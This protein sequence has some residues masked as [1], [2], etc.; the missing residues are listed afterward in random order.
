MSQRRWDDFV[1]GLTVLLTAVIVV[2]VTMWVSG[3]DTG[4]ERPRVEARFRDVGNLQI[5][6]ELLVRG[7]RAGQVE[8]MELVSGGWVQVGFTVDRSALLPPD[9]VVLLGASSLLGEWQATVLDRSELPDNPDVQEAI[10]E[11]SGERDVLPGATLPDLE[12]LTAAAGRIAGDIATVA[13]RARIAFDDSAAREL[14]ESVR[15]L[16]SMSGQLDRTVRVQSENLDAVAAE[17]RA[18]VGRVNAS[19]ASLQ[20]TLA[21]ADSATSGEELQQVM[22]DTR[23][24]AAQL[25]SATAQMDSLVRRLGASQQT[26]ASFVAR[27]DSIAA[28]LNAPDGSL[29]R[30]VND[31]SLYANSDSLLVELRALVADFRANPKRYVSVRI[32]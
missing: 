28:K 25:R 12:Q 32:F 26:V 31:P 29:G 21:R 2:A 17:L 5:G 18:G 4:G 1:V 27:A 19:A 9:P 6:D 14:R 24:T 10:R 30:L 20:R 7:V 15:S 8:A 23:A 13:S 11:A 3:R 22:Q 16:R